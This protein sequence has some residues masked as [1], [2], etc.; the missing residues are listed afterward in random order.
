MLRLKSKYTWPLIIST[1]IVIRLLAAYL[2]PMTQDEAYYVTWGQH[3]DLGYL[4]HPPLIAW[5]SS[6]G[7]IWQGILGPFA[8]RLGGLMLS[9]VSGFFFWRLCSFAGLSVHAQILATI[10]LFGTAAVAL[11][12]ILTTPDVAVFSLWIIA[13]HEAAVAIEKKPK[14]WVSAGALAGLAMLG[15]YTAVLIPIIFLVALLASKKEQLTT[16]WPYLGFATCLIVLSPHLIWN[17][18][19]NWTTFRFILGRGIHESYE[20]Y[21][22]SQSDLPLAQKPEK[23]GPEYIIAEQL[24]DPGDQPEARPDRSPLQKF[25]RRLKNFFGGQLALWGLTVFPLLSLLWS[26]RRSWRALIRITGTTSAE[27]LLRASVIVPLGFFGFVALFANVEANWPS[28]YVI[29]CSVL[30][31]PHLIDRKGM[32]I[33]TSLGNMIIL[34]FLTTLPLTY[35]KIPLPQSVQNNRVLK[36]TTGYPELATVVRHLDKAVCAETYQLAS[37]MDF[38]QASRICQWEGIARPSEWLRRAS[39]NRITRTDLE[40]SFYLLHVRRVPPAISEFSPVKITEYRDCA[41]GKLYVTLGRQG[42]NYSNPCDKKTIHKW[43]LTEYKGNG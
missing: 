5:L 37:M 26:R 29:G 17:A 1:L 43:Y 35:D 10:L 19:H 6:I 38:Y 31:A 21:S 32:I 13:L 28:A 40:G 25:E 41:D 2:L 8:H 18:H 36:E 23:H 4:D 14:R 15:K 30:L 9:G 12:N 3:L 11:T 22:E 27:S 42:Q 39:L 33:I 20:I 34:L 7:N 16:K 24:L